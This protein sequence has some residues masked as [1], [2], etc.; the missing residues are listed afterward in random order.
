MYFSQHPTTRLGMRGFIPKE[1]QQQQQQQMQPL[2]WKFVCIKL[3]CYK[4]RHERINMIN[5]KPYRCSH[6]T[7]RFSTSR[8]KTSRKRILTKRE[9]VPTECEFCTKHFFRDSGQIK[10]K[11]GENTY[12]WEPYSNLDFAE[13]IPVQVT[14]LSMRRFIPKRN[15][16][17][18]IL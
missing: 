4:N 13:E 8:H 10:N 18:K 14:R 17:L 6:C 1:K 2:H 15:G 11:T 5:E 12:Q 9:S 16:Y 3:C 7:L